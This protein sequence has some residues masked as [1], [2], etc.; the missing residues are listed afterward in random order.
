MGIAQHQGV[1]RRG[2]GREPIV[3][4]RM[5]RRDRAR[6]PQLLRRMAR[7][8]FAAGARQV[9]LPVLGL[10]PIDPRL[11]GQDGAGDLRPRDDRAAGQ[12]RALRAAPPSLGIGRELR[13][14]QV[15]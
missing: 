9:Y 3:T 5:S 12:Q 15:S 11:V 8:F 4:Y 1:V 13:G 14:R 10:E 7:T 6:I 2:I